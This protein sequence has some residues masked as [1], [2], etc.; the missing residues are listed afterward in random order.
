VGTLADR[1]HAKRPLLF[2]ERD[3]E[4]NGNDVRPLAQPSRIMDRLRRRA[5]RVL[6]RRAFGVRDLS[7]M[8][9][10]AF[11]EPSFWNEYAEGFAT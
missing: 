9:Y 11:A 10:A 2:F 8:P 1:G 7:A 3:V 5:T 6:D 4:G